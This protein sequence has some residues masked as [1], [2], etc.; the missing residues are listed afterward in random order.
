MGELTPLSRPPEIISEVGYTSANS[1]RVVH[2]LIIVISLLS[3][4]HL[5]RRMVGNYVVVL[6][7]SLLS[8]SNIRQINIGL[9]LNLVLQRID[10][11]D[12]EVR[13]G[14]LND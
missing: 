12:F 5:D 4:P 2:R 7:M 11:I 13:L 6:E 10:L 14:P 9:S 8:V 1:V 3:L